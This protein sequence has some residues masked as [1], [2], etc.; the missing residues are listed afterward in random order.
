MLVSER[1]CFCL[2]YKKVLT[3]CFRVFVEVILKWVKKEVNNIFRWR[4]FNDFIYVICKWQVEIGRDMEIRK[5]KGWFY[6]L[7]GVYKS[8]TYLPLSKIK[9]HYIIG[10]IVFHEFKIILNKLYPKELKVRDLQLMNEITQKWIF[11]TGFVNNVLSS[12]FTIFCVL[13]FNWKE[14]R[15]VVLLISTSINIISLMVF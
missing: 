4:R 11:Y 13:I 15:T 8:P 1:H 9:I 2:T 7:S 12:L 6:Y 3:D 10:D 14:R 5:T